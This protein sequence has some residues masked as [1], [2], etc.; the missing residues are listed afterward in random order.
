MEELPHGWP[1]SGSYNK[2]WNPL[3][4]ASRIGH[5]LLVQRLV[6]E[7]YNSPIAVRLAASEGHGDVVRLLVSN[8][9][10]ASDVSGHKGNLPQHLAAKIGLAET[11]NM[12]LDRGADIGAKNIKGNTALHHA[13]SGGHEAAVGLLLDR[14]ADIGA[15]DENG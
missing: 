14:G 3:E 2:F 1:F 6:R 15:K 7:G 9:V 10:N 5:A 4:G 11:V 8:G 13:A 12:L